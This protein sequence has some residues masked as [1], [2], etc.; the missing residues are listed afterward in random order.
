MIATVQQVDM[1]VAG[2]SELRNP[3]QRFTR[4][5]KQVRSGANHAATATRAAR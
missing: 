1:N 2:R 5:E 3:V 4:R